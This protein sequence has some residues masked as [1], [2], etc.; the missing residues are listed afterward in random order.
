MQF[1]ELIAAIYCPI[2]PALEQLA[3]RMSGK[4]NSSARRKPAPATLRPPHLRARTWVA[5]VGSRRLT[6]W[7]SHAETVN[8]GSNPGLDSD[9]R[10][11]LF[12]AHIVLPTS[13]PAI[14][15]RSD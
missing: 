5:A 10:P 2:V 15:L 3:I 14:G 13:R 6:A 7:A 11:H 12:C 1:T 4:G 8:V 9:N